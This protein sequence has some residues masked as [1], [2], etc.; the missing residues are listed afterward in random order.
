MPRAEVRHE[1]RVYHG[2]TPESIVRRVWGPA[3]QLKW[4]RPEPFSS[5]REAEVV[6]PAVLARVWVPEHAVGEQ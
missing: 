4:S 2:R 5:L 1:G 6:K 3:A